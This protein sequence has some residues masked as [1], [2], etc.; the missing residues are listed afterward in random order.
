[1]REVTL[2]TGAEHDVFS[3]WRRRFCYTQRSGVC[4]AIKRQYRRRCR[5]AEVDAVADSMTGLIE[6]DCD[7]GTCDEC[8]A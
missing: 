4:A 2:T 8:A 1:M 5:R 3:R 7:R 6:N